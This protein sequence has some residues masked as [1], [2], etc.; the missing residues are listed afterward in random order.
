MK[1]AC[2][3]LVLNGLD[4]LPD[5]IDLLLIVSCFDMVTGP[6]KVNTGHDKPYTMAVIPMDND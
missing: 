2:L 6:D 5:L 3:Q 4:M 1:Q